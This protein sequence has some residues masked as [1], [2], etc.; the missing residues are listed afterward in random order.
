M[1]ARDAARIDVYALGLILR[2]MLLGVPPAGDSAA[3]PGDDVGCPCLPCLT[4]KK[5]PL[6]V[7]DVSELPPAAAA[8]P[9]RNRRGIPNPWGPAGNNRR[10]RPWRRSWEAFFDPASP[11]R[12]P[13]HTHPFLG[14]RLSCR[15]RRTIR[16]AQ[17]DGNELPPVRRR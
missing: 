17:R 7:R 1:N 2:Y 11:A 14:G 15:P 6:L 4:V 13:S 12:S 5:P 16:A 9:S 10:H 8:L 3:A